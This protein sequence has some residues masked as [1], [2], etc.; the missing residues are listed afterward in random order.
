MCHHLII[1]DQ[2][3]F[4]NQQFYVLLTMDRKAS[5]THFKQD[6]FIHI[7]VTSIAAGTLGQEGFFTLQFG[8]LKG[9]SPL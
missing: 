2:A 7:N 3:T 8:E 9:Q 6:T 4:D 5:L 1:N